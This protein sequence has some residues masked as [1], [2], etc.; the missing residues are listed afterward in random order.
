MDPQA[1][2][3]PI[4]LGRIL[5]RPPL[6]TDTPLRG[7]THLTQRWR[8]GAL[9]DYLPG[10]QSHVL[11]T[12]YANPRSISFQTDRQRHLSQTRPGTITIIPAGVGGRWDIHGAIEVSHVY[13]SPE[14]LQ[15]SARQLTGGKAFELLD[16]VGFEDPSAARIL[17]MLSREAGL[18][19]PSATL[20]VEQAIDLLCLQLMRAHTSLTSLPEPEPR[21]G[22]ATWQVKK[23]TDYM[24]EHLAE[25]VSLDELAG[26]LGLSRFYFCTAFRLAT[27]QT[28]HDWLRQQ[29]IQ[30]ARK[31]LAE[32]YLSVTEVGLAVGYGTPS[33][34]SAAFRKLVGMTPTAYRRGV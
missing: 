11:V 29:R 10:L 33:A 24:L 13:L 30:L 1:A 31:L 3:A 25:E 27:D 6:L 23:V 19:D 14:R 32:P 4:E 5:D 20:F 26:L 15:D 7:E 18:S 9:H 2:T 28:P 16:R 17:E 8:H 21:R 22:L 12:Y 34:F